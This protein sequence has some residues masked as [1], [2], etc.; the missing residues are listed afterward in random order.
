MAAENAGKHLR[1]A[2]VGAVVDEDA[3]GPLG[4]SRPEI[5]FPSSHPDEAQ[6]VEVDIV[7]MATPDMPEE[8]R[9]AEAVVRRLSKGAGARDGAAAIIE[10]VSRNATCPLP[11]LARPSARV[12]SV[13]FHPLD[14]AEQPRRKRGRDIGRGNLEA[15]ATVADQVP[16]ILASN[17]K[18]RPLR[19]GQ[20]PEGRRMGPPEKLRFLFRIYANKRVKKA[21]RVSDDERKSISE[22]MTPNGPAKRMNLSSLPQ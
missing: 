16:T 11:I 1:L 20:V 19:V 3:S 17:A 12:P 4:L 18:H 10:P 6:T 14:G 7:V 9:L 2:L 8:D 15:R 22:Q 5:A 21:V 13:R